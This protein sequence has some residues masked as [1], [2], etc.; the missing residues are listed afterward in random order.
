MGKI[1]I[2]LDVLRN[3][4]RHNWRVNSVN[5]PVTAMRISEKLVD[6]YL[7]IYHVCM[8]FLLLP[9]LIK[10]NPYAI[11]RVCTCSAVLPCHSCARGESKKSSTTVRE[12]FTCNQPA[13]IHSNRV[14]TKL[15]PAA[16]PPLGIL[17]L[18][19]RHLR[20]HH[21]KGTATD[22]AMPMLPS[23]SATQIFRPRLRSEETARGRTSHMRLPKGR[24]MRCT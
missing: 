3:S 5:P 6:S 12:G 22:S 11:Q 16:A 17:S 21:Q 14:H 4:P 19:S 15:F 10:S 1:Y 7:K 20:F 24:Y 23:P 2:I 8:S 18:R 9:V 13:M